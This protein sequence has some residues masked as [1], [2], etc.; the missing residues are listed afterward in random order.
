MKILSRIIFTISIASPHITSVPVIAKPS[1]H[2]IGFVKILPSKLQI[3]A[4]GYSIVGSKNQN[5]L[6]F[7]TGVTENPLI[8]IDGKNISLELV[9][10][11]EVRRNNQVVNSIRKYKFNI[12]KVTTDFRDKT[13]ARDKKEYIARD[14]G[15]I[16]VTSNDGWKK[17]INAECAY[18]IGG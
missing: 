14:G 8:N 9:S 6:V 17:K 11:K 18:D 12:F 3:G 13:R 2:K 5:N 1:Y 15:S 16:F 4:C 7:V 10:E